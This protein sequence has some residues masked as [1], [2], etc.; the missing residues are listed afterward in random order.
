MQEPALD[1]AI[2]ALG[3]GRQNGSSCNVPVI[4]LPNP[5][6]VDRKTM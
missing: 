1:A 5:P 6:D 4:T 3:C 2:G